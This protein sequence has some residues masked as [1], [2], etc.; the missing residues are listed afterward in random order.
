MVTAALAVPD[1][2]RVPWY[3]PP[4]SVAS[5]LTARLME[6]WAHGQDIAD[7]LGAPPVASER[8]RH[9]VFLGW[10]A[11]PNSFAARG[12]PA[13]EAPVRVEVVSPAG[14][15]WTF[16]PDDAADRVSGPALDLAL[17]VTQRRHLDDLA[18]VAEGPVAHQ[19]LGIAQAFAGPPGPGRRPGQ[20]DPVVR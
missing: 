7:A 14:E 18:V 1:G 11:I 15:C 19:W 4:M 16:G 3:G 10:R 6:T 17:A 12:L 13:P 8:L 9:V 2:T 5:Q 20:F